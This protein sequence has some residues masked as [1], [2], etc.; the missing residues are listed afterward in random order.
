MTDLTPPEDLIDL[1][2]QWLAAQ[3]LAYKIADEEPQGQEEIHIPARHAAD[4]PRTVRLFSDEQN[5][6]LNAARAEVQ[7]LTLEIFRHPWKKNPPA[8]QR[9]EAEQA[10]NEAAEQRWK[11][12]LS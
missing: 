4:Q 1:K 2:A 11:A 10:L 6:R 3:A 12:T 5:D 7:R 8:G 9:Q